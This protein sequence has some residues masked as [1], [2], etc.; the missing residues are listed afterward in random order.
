MDSH[1]GRVVDYDL[2]MVLRSG[3]RRLLVVAAASARTVYVLSTEKRGSCGAV[4]GAAIWTSY[5]K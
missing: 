3:D 2:A 5:L 1:R 4:P